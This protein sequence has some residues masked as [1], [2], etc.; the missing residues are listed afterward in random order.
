MAHQVLGIKAAEAAHHSQQQTAGHDH[1]HGE[2]AAAARS[3]GFWLFI[4]LLGGLLVLTSFFVQWFSPIN[5]GEYLYQ[6]HMDTAAGLGA[7]LL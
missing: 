5:K 6:F 1:S 3:A 2:A 4:T 7:L